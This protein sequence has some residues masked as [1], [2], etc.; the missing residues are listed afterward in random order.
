MKKLTFEYAKQLYKKNN[1]ELLEN[2]YINAHIKMKTRCCKCNYIWFI[3]LNNVNSE[4]NCPAC[5]K[6]LKYS[7]EQAKQ[8]FL[9]ANLTLLEKKYKSANKKMKY[10]CNECKYKG[11]ITLWNVK[12]GNRCHRCAGTLKHTIK[13]AQ[14]IFKT[15]NLSLLEKKYFGNQIKMQTECNK[16]GYIW[17]ITLGNVHN[18]NNCPKCSILKS[19][20]YTGKIIEQLFPTE[21]IIIHDRKLLDGLE[22][23]ILCHNKK[24]IVE[25][26]GIQHYK[27]SNHFHRTQEV[28]EKTKLHDKLK[29]E[30]AKQK[31][32][33]LIIVPYWIKQK[34]IENYLINEFQKANIEV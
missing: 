5:A 23:D 7:I 30:R 8:I 13:T 17:K 10:I 31:G 16:C 22:C 4:N 21:Q 2:K 15:H 20:K 9:K 34:D 3:N 19:E 18:G 28:F 29:I 32:Y 25:Y 11:K 12:K 33:N 27:F 24:F 6:T 14:K 1:L 26:N